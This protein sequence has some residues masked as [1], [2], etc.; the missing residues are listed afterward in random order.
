MTAAAAFVLAVLG[1]A[2]V[3]FAS[4]RVRPDLVAAL[5]LLSLVVS[6]VVAPAQAF[7]GFSSLAVIA[8]AGLM[9]VGDGLER[10]GVVKWVARQL[11]HVI[12]ESRGRLLILNTTIPAVL[13]GFVNIVAAAGFFIPVVLRLCRKM[14]EPQSKI[15]LP[16]ACMALLGA[17]LTLIGASHNLVVHSLL[18]GSVG[19]GFAFFEFTALGAVLIA[20]ALVYLLVLGRHLLPGAEA[21]P[22]PRRIPVV[23]NLVEVYELRDRVFEVWLSLE[24]GADPDEVPSIAE[25][26]LDEQGLTVL[27]VVREEGRLRFPPA[28]APLAD[29]D[30]LLVQGR[31]ER[32]E[33]ACEAHDSL[34]FMGPPKAQEA[35]PLSTA[36]LVEAVVPPRSPAIGRTLR[37]L[38]LLEE[39]GMTAV[40]YHRDGRPHRTGV[41]DTPLAPGDG[42]LFYGPRDRMR[43]FD[44]EKD[45]L[46]YFKPAEPEVTL[47]ARRKA[48]LAALILLLVILSAALGLFPI[49]VSA[50]AGA[51]AMVC[52]GIVRAARIYDAVDWRSLVLVA[53]MYPLGL[54]LQ[55]TGAADAIGEVLVGS[56]GG[57]GPVAVL[58]GVVALTMLLT[59]PIHNAAVAIIMTPIAINAAELTGSDP[60]GFCVAVV[61]ACSAAFLMPYGHPAPLL[62]QEPGG[63][64]PL[65]Y[66][67]FG[68]GLAL[69]TFAVVLVLVP[70]LW[71]L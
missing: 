11:E 36:D 71:P 2:F 39:F 47:R 8:I 60:R 49:A 37:E 1:A 14:E 9:I 62:V 59:Q 33:A 68:A 7:A 40:A 23:A 48:P 63:Y 65:D 12:R 17:N 66:L 28:G 25:L 19:R 35:Y 70:V 3:L 64:R 46:L 54:A 44:P 32:V 24:E 56:L 57:Y 69:I 15:L 27:A 61:V 5:V 52:T 30:M 18:E 42:I 20:A 26:G 34:T 10:T 53:G 22:D 51:V 29:G 31:R 45:L 4:G 16:M 6:G 43:E 55:E 58:A 21:T 13:S 67:R 50:L 41:L 38:D